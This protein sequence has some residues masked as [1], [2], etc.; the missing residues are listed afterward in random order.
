MCHPDGILIHVPI[1]VDIYVSPLRGFC[2]ASLAMRLQMCH[3]DGIG[4][5]PVNG[6]SFPMGD[7]S[8]PAFNA[9]GMVITP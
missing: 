7:Q 8:N 1:C 9:G 2:F 6:K 4:M 5:I 3:P